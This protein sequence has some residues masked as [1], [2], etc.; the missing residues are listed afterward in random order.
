MGYFCWTFRGSNFMIRFVGLRMCFW[1]ES[2]FMFVKMSTTSDNSLRKG[3]WGILRWFF[4]F[5]YFR[6][7]SD[8]NRIFQ[9]KFFIKTLV[10]CRLDT[11][12]LIII[13]FYCL[14]V[15]GKVVSCSKRSGG[16]ILKC[17]FI[18]SSR[19]VVYQKV[20]KKNH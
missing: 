19:L 20:V 18:F 3:R 7:F 10:K 8:W 1:K 2:Y 16:D 9:T 4:N 14:H 5:Q 17:H 6:P 15:F 12:V 13:W 11:P